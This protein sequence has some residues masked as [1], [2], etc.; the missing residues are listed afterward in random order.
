MIHCTLNMTR[1]R[2]DAD[3]YATFYFY[4]DARFARVCDPDANARPSGEY[5]PSK[6]QAGFSLNILLEPHN[7]AETWPSSFFHFD[8][9]ELSEYCEFPLVENRLETHLA[10]VR[11]TYVIKTRF[12]I[13]RK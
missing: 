2:H 5:K 1:R 7:L 12:V 11:H 10:R 4:I 9:L 8:E 6:T 13:V 3:P